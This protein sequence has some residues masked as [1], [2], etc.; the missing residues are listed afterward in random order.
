MWHSFLQVSYNVYIIYIVHIIWAVEYVL[1]FLQ[2]E[3]HSI[4]SSLSL[5]NFGS[6]EHTFMSQ[7][8]KLG[9]CNAPAREAISL[10]P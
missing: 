4:D 3:G 10:S 7:V 1:T 8:P 9:H 2:S 5:E 6:L